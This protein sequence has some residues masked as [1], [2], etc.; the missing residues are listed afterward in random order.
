MA[1]GKEKEE[2]NETKA[3][4]QVPSTTAHRTYLPGNPQP[5]NRDSIPALV[6]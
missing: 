1:K 4:L 3:N 2:K 6:I 5:G